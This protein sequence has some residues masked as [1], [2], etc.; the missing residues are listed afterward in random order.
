MHSYGPPARR[1]GTKRA[2]TRAAAQQEARRLERKERLPMKVYHCD[3]CG[4]WHVAHEHPLKRVTWR[5]R[6]G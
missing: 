1:C 6:N 2:L 5:E 4:Q 3:V